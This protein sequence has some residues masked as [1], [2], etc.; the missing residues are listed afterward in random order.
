MTWLTAVWFDT[1]GCAGVLALLN[2]GCG[3]LGLLLLKPQR[4]RRAAASI[5]SGIPS[6]EDSF[7]GT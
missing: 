4:Q 3:V 7:K 1:R 6:P 2:V 5:E